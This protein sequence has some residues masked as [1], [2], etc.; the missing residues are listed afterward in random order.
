MAGPACLPVSGIAKISIYPAHPRGTRRTDRAGGEQFEIVLFGEFKDVVETVDVDADSEGDVG[1]A[2]D[3]QQR[4]EMHDPVNT[5]VHHQLLQ[6]L[7]IK[8]V[9]VDIW[10]CTQPQ[11]QH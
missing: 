2:N 10:P 9:C 3:T 7:E 11:R 6:F 8:D 1:L 4:A 5:L